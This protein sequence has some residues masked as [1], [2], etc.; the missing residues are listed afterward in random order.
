MAVSSFEDIAALIKELCDKSLFDKG[1]ANT[2]LEDI[3]NENVLVS[4]TIAGAL[5]GL[6]DANKITR[7]DAQ[8]YLDRLGLTQD[9]LDYHIGRN[10]K[11]QEKKRRLN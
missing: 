3:A 8:P 1:F 10:R 2:L 9:E 11:K 6:I 5:H 4:V 7:S